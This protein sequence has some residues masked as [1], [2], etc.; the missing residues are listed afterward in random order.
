M[1][2]N[3]QF[4]PDLIASTAFIAR[5][6]VIVGEVTLAEETSV[7]FNATLRGD[8]EPIEVGSRSNVQEGAIFHADPGFPA[9]VG[10]G[11]TVGHG[12]VIHGATVGDN[13]IIG[14]RA[15]LLNGARVGENCIVGAN[16]L[17]TEGKT[18]P[19]GSLIIGSPAKV[20]RSLAPE[21][22]EQIAAAA[23]SYV[24]RSR[25]FM[26]SGQWGMEDRT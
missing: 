17:L 4:R 21:E 13:S 8:N 25:A 9:V 19:P 3:T 18:F 23:E 11:V 15:V 24:K 5:G 6:V 2:Y 12:A 26:A 10:S 1:S 14:M 20:V 16:S 22:I 7:W